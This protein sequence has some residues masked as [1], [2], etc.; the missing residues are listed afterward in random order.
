M[1]YTK[2]I[3]QADIFISGDP[4]KYENKIF[5]FLLWGIKRHDSRKYIL[6]EK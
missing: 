5:T 1:D 6:I 2:S 4:F 3:L